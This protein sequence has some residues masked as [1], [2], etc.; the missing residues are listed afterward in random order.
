MEQQDKD[1][2]ESEHDLLLY[3]TAKESQELLIIFLMVWD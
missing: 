3:A 1:S 2:K